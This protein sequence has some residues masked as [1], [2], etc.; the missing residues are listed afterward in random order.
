MK[1]AQSRKRIPLF[2][3][4][5]SK[6]ARDEVADTLE[7][8]WLTAGP[9]TAAFEEATAEALEA[10]YT[11][12]L[13]SCTSA[14][15]LSLMA[16]AGD[17]KAEVVTTPYTFVATAEAILAA[18][19]QPVLA[20]IDPATLNVDPDEV[21]RKITDHT[22]AVMPVDIAGHPADYDRL[23]DI[24][25]A[26]KVPLISDSAHAF[27][28]RWRDKT[29]PNW[30]DASAYS[31][32]S[33]KNLTCGEGGLLAS[34]HESLIDAVRTMSRHGLSSNAFDRQ[35]RSEWSYDGV[36]FGTKANMSDV[37][38]AIGLGELSVFEDNQR[39]RQ[40][41]AEAYLDRLADLSDLAALPI[42]REQAG[43]SWH[44]FI[45]KLH[46]SR[47]KITR[48]QFIE[49][50]AERGV[51][52]GVHYPPLFALSFYRDV[53]EWKGQHYPNAAYAGERAVS[54]PLYPTLSDD[55]AEYVCE[56]AASILTGEMR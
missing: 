46:L 18:G 34:R 26:K 45:V 3:V 47:L 42:A 14:L 19:A 1:K 16:L 30:A 12:A 5:V 7:S 9:K 13:N 48:N 22:L 37:Q 23:Q 51:E 15:Q 35:E 20:D 55:D 8:G 40:E 44:L 27:G 31:F 49:S 32:Y 25:D 21:A 54:L 24:C 10:P 36:M 38:A 50:M 39:R 41:L 29:I 4:S 28:S 6:A 52:C 43:H 53:L 17:D 2:D 56:C 11:V 33:T